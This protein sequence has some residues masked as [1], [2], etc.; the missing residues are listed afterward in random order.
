MPNP[1]TTLIAPTFDWNSTEQYENFQLF[2]KSV[3]SWFTLQH[4]TA[5]AT[6]G[7]TSNSTRLEYV[8]NFLGNTGCKKY[9]QW[10]PP[11][12]NVEVKKKKDSA[13]E[14]LDYTMD[15]KVSKRCRIYQLEDV[16]AHPGESPD[17]LVD[18]LRALADGCNFPSEEEKERNVQYRFVRALDNKELVKKLLA[19]DL[20]ATTAKMLEVCHIHIVS[21]DNLNTMGL[22]G[23]KSVN[24]V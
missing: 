9:E 1:S 16:S 14:F 2:I 4:I 17:E 15:H 10:K 3:N 8:L 11:G 5:E 19:L 18:H 20:K 6:P 23:P 24:A 22:S 12:T 7:G 21:S 13:K